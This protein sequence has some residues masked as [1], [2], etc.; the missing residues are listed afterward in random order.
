MRQE[1]KDLYCGVV[2]D[3]FAIAILA[4]SFQIKN[5]TTSTFDISSR[6][7][8]R[9]CAVLILVLG[10]ILIVRNAAKL[11]GSAKEVRETDRN[12]GEKTTGSVRML[13]AIGS[14]ILFV[15]LL[16]KLG[17]IICGT[18]ITFVLMWVL[19]PKDARTP[20]DLVKYFI[21]SL[22]LAVLVDLLFVRAFYLMLPPGIL[23]F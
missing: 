14:L 12:S 7:F 15:I 9:I 3:A 21:I 4:F 8:P 2:L 5:I 22:V 13:I 10:T 17:F 6:T 11:S 19:A 1:K 23:S 16:P 20:K 18:L